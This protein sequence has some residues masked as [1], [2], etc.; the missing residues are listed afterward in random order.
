LAL[1]ALDRVAPNLGPALPAAIPGRGLRRAAAV[2]AAAAALFPLAL[3]DRYQRLDLQGRRD[4]LYVLGFCRGTLNAAGKLRKGA[5]VLF[6]MDERRFAP[7]GFETSQLER[8]RWF[9]RE[10]WGP[11]AHYGTAEVFMEAPRATLVLPCL[12]PAPIEVTL[13]MSARREV[14]VRA[15][16]NGRFLGEGVVGPDRTRLRFEVPA[17]ALFR[18]DN[19]V[20][21]EVPAGAEFAPRLYAVAYS[22]LAITLR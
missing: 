14:P 8:M 11:D 1:L 5:A 13:A 3:V 10:G 15:S 9:L 4:G 12:T 19:V 2:A 21:V 22:P 6:K 17:A 16:V 18:G 20:A 7:R